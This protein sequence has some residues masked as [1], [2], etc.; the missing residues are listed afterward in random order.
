MVCFRSVL[1]VALVRPSGK[2]VFR[3]R[4]GLHALSPPQLCLPVMCSTSIAHSG[5]E[6]PQFRSSGVHLLTVLRLLQH[7]VD[8]TPPQFYCL[9]QKRAA[10]GKQAGAAGGGACPER[11]RR[12]TLAPT[13]SSNVALNPTGEKV[14]LRAYF[15]PHSA[16]RFEASCSSYFPVSR[17]HGHVRETS[18]RSVAPNAKE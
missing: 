9:R 15:F 16:P 5:R 18:R 3:C 13:L 10:L 8:P 6:F 2:L 7:G 1:I 17:K 14:E 4:V 12:G 11:H